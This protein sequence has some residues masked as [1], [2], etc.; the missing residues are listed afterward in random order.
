[1]EAVSVYHVWISLWGTLEEHS[2]TGF[3]VP[4]TAG[5]KTGPGDRRCVIETWIHRRAQQQKFSKSS[6]YPLFSP[7]FPLSAAPRA[8]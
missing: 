6:V 3:T 5:R 1:M 7:A 4:A 8:A 2:G